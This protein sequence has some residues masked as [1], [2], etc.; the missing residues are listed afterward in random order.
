VKPAD[1]GTS[2]KYNSDLHRPGRWMRVLEM[3]QFMQKVKEI[4]AQIQKLSHEEIAELRAWFLE[5]DWSDWDAELEAD[6]NTG[7]LDKL[8][9]EAKSEYQSGRARK[10]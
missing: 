10:L 7:K 2:I 5:Q 9:S 8:V 1:L 3:E 6:V 4:E